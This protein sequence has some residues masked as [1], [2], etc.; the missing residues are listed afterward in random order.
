MYQNSCLTSPEGFHIIRVRMKKELGVA[1][2]IGILLGFGISAFLWTK[3][4]GQKKLALN[5]Q[6]SPTLAQTTPTAIPTKTTEKEVFLN[7]IQPDNEIVASNENLIIKGETIPNATIVVIWEEGEEISVADKNG[8][9]E[10]NIELIGGENIINIS[11]YDNQ[12]NKAT[13]TL[14]VTYSTA[15]F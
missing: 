10:T 6:T 12:G 7:I 14:T 3:N 8:E 1:I 2:F 15:K 13:Q 5:N 4:K 11:S 9:F